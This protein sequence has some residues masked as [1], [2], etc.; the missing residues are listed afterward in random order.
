ML[1]FVPS[2]LQLRGNGGS[3]HGLASSQSDPKLSLVRT[4]VMK[5]AR[6][7]SLPNGYEHH[8]RRV[9]AA[10]WLAVSMLCACERRSH[11]AQP[12]PT[13]GEAALSHAA[14]A[15]IALADTARAAIARE[16]SQRA[17]AYCAT[18][19]RTY[20]AQR[21]ECCGGAPVPLFESQCVL[22]VSDGLRRQAVDIDELRLEVCARE[23]NDGVRG[24]AWVTPHRPSAPSSCIEALVA[25]VA[26]GGS[27]RS[28]LECVGDAH[29]VGHTA[30]EA[31]VCQAPSAVGD[32]CGVSVDA[33]ATFVRAGDW[34]Q[35]HPQCVGGCSLETHR[36]VESTNRL[37]AEPSQVTAGQACE[38]D[39]DCLQGACAS[40]EHGERVCG[41]KCGADLGVLAHKFA[42]H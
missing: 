41:M 26:L 5:R 12:V 37:A 14:R 24:C 3:A 25:Q 1:W 32:A 10:G 18:L 23:L 7:S 39:A 6:H 35:T 34:E 29:C 40:G 9:S 28:S 38:S 22:H 19:H 20:E 27:C 33:L 8:S 15:D 2:I 13:S 42:A 11:D 31:G 4:R 21:A 30:V 17:V 36:C 16:P